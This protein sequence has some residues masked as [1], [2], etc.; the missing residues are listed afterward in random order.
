MLLIDP[1]KLD[2]A[3]NHVID[4]RILAQGSDALLRR[5]KLL[6]E[7]DRLL[8]DM[9]LKHRLSRRQIGTVLGLTPGGVTRKLRRVMNRLHDPLVAALSDPDCTLAPEFRQIGI[10][11]FLHRRPLKELS[12][13]H[14]VSRQ[15]VRSTLDYL[16][17]WHRG[18]SA[19]R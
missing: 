2:H 3:T 9:A 8:I 4:T 10:E 18:I 17:G 14:R 15:E 13:L 19:R 1:R 5:Y 16:R 12:R 6:G 11:Y 7:Q